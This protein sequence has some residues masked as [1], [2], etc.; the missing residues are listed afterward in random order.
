MILILILIVLILVVCGSGAGIAAGLIEMAM[1]YL[2]TTGKVILD[3]LVGTATGAIA[4]LFYRSSPTHCLSSIFLGTLYWFF[5]GT[6]FGELYMAL[7]C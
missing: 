5:Y 2:G 4:G 3:V 7:M 1:G 6:A